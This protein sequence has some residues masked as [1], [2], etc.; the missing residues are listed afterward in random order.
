MG[1]A[2]AYRFPEQSPVSSPRIRVVP[3]S[4]PRARESALPDQALLIAKAMIAALLVFA[5][6][7]FAR[8]ALSAATVQTAIASE[9][10]SVNIDTARATGNE[11]EVRQS[12][13]SNPTSIKQEASSRLGMAAPTET[14]T[15]TL[16][17][18]VV[19]TDEA[20]NLSLALS[21]RTAG[22]VASAAAANEAVTA[23]AEPAAAVLG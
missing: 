5:V 4:A 20:G 18:D 8:V 11:L 6:A 13:L 23:T 10:I 17:K 9:D 2:P 14:F 21:V 15:I 19:T 3:G 22:E 16:E 12:Y 1:A 7:G